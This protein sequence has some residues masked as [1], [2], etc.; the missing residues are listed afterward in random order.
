MSVWVERGSVE[1][2]Q[3]ADVPVIMVGPGTGCAP[4][5]SFIHDRTS[6]QIA[7]RSDHSAPCRRY[8]YIK[9]CLFFADFFALVK[10]D[11]SNRS[12]QS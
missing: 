3:T 7:G 6:Q 12:N 10:R 11:E 5:R 2:P 4:F 9:L 8:F 1:F